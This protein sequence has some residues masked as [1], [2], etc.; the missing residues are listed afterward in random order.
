VGR[1]SAPARSLPSITGRSKK[2]AARLP[3]AAPSPC[4]HATRN[5]HA[6][7]EP[8]GRAQ[9]A[10]DERQDACWPAAIRAVSVTPLVCVC[11]RARAALPCPS[12]TTLQKNVRAGKDQEESLELVVMLLVL[13]LL[14]C[15]L[16]K[17]S[18]LAC[19]TDEITEGDAG[20]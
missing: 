12:C 14:T 13:L 18:F 6:S 11:V 3:P 16:V 5:L 1:A 4:F 2:C 17:V 10:L 15:V 8:Q 19:F 20:W 7:A 9:W